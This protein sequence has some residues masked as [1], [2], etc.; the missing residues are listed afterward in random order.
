MAIDR[1]WLRAEADRLGLTLTDDDLSAIA[2]SVEKIRAELAAAKPDS[3]ERDDT[4]IG[5][6]PLSDEPPP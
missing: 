4:A 1:A 2:Q 3:P 6:L 5:F